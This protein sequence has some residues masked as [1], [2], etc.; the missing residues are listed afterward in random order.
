[1]SVQYCHHVREEC[2]VCQLP[3]DPGNEER[4]C[5]V[6]P[7]VIPTASWPHPAES[8]LFIHDQT[9][10]SVEVFIRKTLLT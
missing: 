1:M 4:Q 10:S 5:P 8:V 9:T 3:G 7:S 2:L 6:Y